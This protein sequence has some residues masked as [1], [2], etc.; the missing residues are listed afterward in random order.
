MECKTIEFRRALADA[1]AAAELRIA[2]DAAL[3]K[4]HRELDRRYAE[5]VSGVNPQE[6][7]RLNRALRHAWKLD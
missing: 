4:R 6:C 2:A 5:A 3:A 7:A 1:A